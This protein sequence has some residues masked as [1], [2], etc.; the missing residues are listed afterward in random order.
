MYQPYGL[1]L[2]H[3]LYTVSMRN[4]LLTRYAL[5]LVVVNTCGRLDVNLNVMSQHHPWLS[6]H[7]L[8]A[9]V[10]CMWQGTRKVFGWRL[11]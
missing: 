4:M 9:Q 10:V 3:T 5:A 8:Y 7:K 11:S 6:Q 1:D 2:V